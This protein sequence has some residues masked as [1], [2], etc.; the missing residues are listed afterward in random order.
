MKI[1]PIILF[2]VIAFQCDAQK[3]VFKELKL[4]PNTKYYNTKEATIVFPIV[5]TNNPKIDK[6]INN[7]IKIDVLQPEDETHSLRKVLFE[8][9]NEFGLTDVSYEI[10]YNKNN[11]LSFSVFSQGCGAYCS[12][13]TSYFNFDL[14]TGKKI[15]IDELIIKS[16]IDSF[17]NIVQ[18]D[19]VNTLNKY[20]IEEK[21]S[22]GSEGVDSSTYDWAISTV[23]EN[24]IN[25]I[26]IENFSVSPSLLQIFDPCDF[27]HI[28]RSQEP[29][30]ELK[31]SFK[32]I[33]AFLTPKFKRMFLNGSTKPG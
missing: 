6:L 7:Q 13:G 16:K 3:A 4:K 29:E 27:P 9:I 30:I 17:K 23:D 14:L 21:N 18:A 20:K 8:N 28:I 26:S 1:L 33:E 22:I 19:K 2:F 11:I 24:C 10:T 25:K 31:Y 5:A 12:S 15:S 32:S